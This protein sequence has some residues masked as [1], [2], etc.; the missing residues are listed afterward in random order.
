MNYIEEAVDIVG[1]AVRA[2]SSNLAHAKDD[3]LYWAIVAGGEPAPLWLEGLRGR[4]FCHIREKVEYY[5]LEST[6]IAT[7]IFDD[8]DLEFDSNSIS[9]SYKCWVLPLSGLDAVQQ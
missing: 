3:I 2:L 5:H 8:R 7:F 4:L 9:V 1:E 6:H